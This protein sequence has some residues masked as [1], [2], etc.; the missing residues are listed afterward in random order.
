MLLFHLAL[1]QA[2]V[3]APTTL[4]FACAARADGRMQ[5]WAFSIDRRTGHYTGNH[6]AAELGGAASVGEKEIVLR[7]E[8]AQVT[9]YYHINRTTRVFT[10]A[11]GLKDRTRVFNQTRGVCS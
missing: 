10:V 7:S 8:E 1:A 11:F 5:R 3:P 6:D 4:E 9:W 2:V